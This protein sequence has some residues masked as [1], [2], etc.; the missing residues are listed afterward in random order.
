MRRG[1]TLLALLLGAVRSSEAQGVIV[2]PHAVFMDHRARSA[3]ITLY[4]PG[5]EPAEVTISSFFG[6][7]V[8]DSLGHFELRAPDSVDASMP[9]ATE[10][11]EA[12]PRRMTLAPLQRQTIRLL[13]R[14]PQGLAD[15]EYWSRVVISAKGGAVPVTGADSGAIA[16]GLALEVR[17]IIPLLYRKGQ[18]KTGIALTNLRAERVGDSLVVRARLDRQGAAA[19]IG[20][21]RGALVSA[22]GATVGGFERPVAVYYDVEP[23]FTLPVPPEAAGSYRLRLELTGDRTDIPPELLLRSPPV[24]DSI[25]V[26]LP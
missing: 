14:P 2:A 10:W 19:W 6:Y 18:L 5:S 13:A 24:R 15:G 8:T 25:E 4:N 20:T 22:K 12:F 1:L 16:I 17:S 21:A 7:P 26:R 23:S 11:I 9:S 3:S